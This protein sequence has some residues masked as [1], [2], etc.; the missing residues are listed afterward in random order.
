LVYF[1]PY[2]RLFSRL[3]GG[4]KGE[5]Q[6]FYIVAV[7]LSIRGPINRR[8]RSWSVMKKLTFFTLGLPLV[9]VLG[10]QSSGSIDPTV[11]DATVVSA[12]SQAEADSLDDVSAGDVNGAAE[13]EADAAIDQEVVI[14]ND[15]SLS[16]VHARILTTYDKDGDGQLSMQEK[17]ALTLD[18]ASKSGTRVNWGW[19]F[20]LLRLTWVYDSDDSGMLDEQERQIRRQDLEVRCENRLEQFLAAYD[21]D[22]DGALDKAE[23]TAVRE[24]VKAKKQAKIDQILAEFDQ[25]KDGKLNREERHAFVKALVEKIWAKRQAAITK[26]DADDDG[27]LNASEKS[28][29][30]QYLRARV[31]GEDSDSNR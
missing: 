12:L 25:N 8:K 18:V 6:L 26:F 30:R 4:S 11:D 10:C 3:A 5:T 19:Q 9:G 29:L 21:T 20:R 31:R 23:W 16:A 14:E 13:E 28:S 22:K 17:I 15:C 24:A 27:K 2:R 7:Y 1:S